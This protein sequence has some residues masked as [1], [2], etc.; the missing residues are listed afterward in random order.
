[1]RFTI[2]LEF[3]VSYCHLAREISQVYLLYIFIFFVFIFKNFSAGTFGL[4][5]ATTY[6]RFS[7]WAAA[8]PITC[9]IITVLSSWV[10]TGS[11]L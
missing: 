6:N 4:A 11:V 9:G 10:S 3:L 7:L 1:M 8:V 2:I 5:L